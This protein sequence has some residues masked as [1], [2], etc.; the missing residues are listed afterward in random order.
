L[1]SR[2]ADVNA[3]DLGGNTP[4]HYAIAQA[5]IEMVIL[6]LDF[7]AD[8]VLGDNDNV[9]AMEMVAL[10]KNT[11]AIQAIAVV[12][13]RHC[14]KY[15]IHVAPNIV[16]ALKSKNINPHILD[17]ETA[18]KEL[19]M[20]QEQQH[21][22]LTALLQDAL[23]RA[24]QVSQPEPVSGKALDHESTPMEELP[25][26]E[27]HPEASDDNHSSYSEVDHVDDEPQSQP[28]SLQQQPQQQQPPSSPTAE[29][30]FTRD[31]DNILDKG[32]ESPTSPPVRPATKHLS[33]AT[34]LS[35]M[36]LLTPTML[37]PFLPSS[38]DPGDHSPLLTSPHDPKT[39]QPQPVPPF[40]GA[41][42]HGRRAADDGH[43]ASPSPSPSRSRSSTT[44]T[45]KPPMTI[46]DAM[47]TGQLLQGPASQSPSSAAAATS[48]HAVSTKMRSQPPHP[49]HSTKTLAGIPELH[50]ASSAT[51]SPTHRRP[52]SASNSN[53]VGVVVQ[54]HPFVVSMRNG[55]TGRVLPPRHKSAS[56]LHPTTSMTGDKDGDH[57]DRASPSSASS[58]SSSLQAIHPHS[59]HPH[60]QRQQQQ[61]QS[62]VYGD[63]TPSGGGGHV[64]IRRATTMG[65]GAGG[66]GGLRAI[67]I[68]NQAASSTS[69]PD[70]A[71]AFSTPQQQQQFMMAM[72]APPALARDDGTISEADDT[73]ASGSPAVVSSARGSHRK[74]HHHHHHHHIAPTNSVS[75][76]VMNAPSNNHNNHNHHH[77]HTNNNHHHLRDFNNSVLAHS[78]PAGQK[79]LIQQLLA[80]LPHIEPLDALTTTTT[81]MTQQP[82]PQ[83]QQQRD[84]H[85]ANDRDNDDDDDDRLPFFAAGIVQQHRLLATQVQTLHQHLQSQLQLLQQYQQQQTVA[86]AQQAQ[87]AQAQAPQTSSSGGSVTN[88][89]TTV[90]TSTANGILPP[91]TIHIPT[92]PPTLKAQHWQ[93]QLSRKRQHESTSKPSHP[94]SSSSSSSRMTTATTSSTTMMFPPAPVVPFLPDFA[95]TYAADELGDFAPEHCDV[96]VAVEHCFDCDRHSNQ[97]LRHDTRT[98]VRHA[99]AVLAALVRAIADARLAVRLFAMRSPPLTTRRLGAFEVTVAVRVDLPAAASPLPPPSSSSTSAFHLRNTHT[100]NGTGNN[101]NGNGSKGTGTGGATTTTPT[102]SKNSPGHFFGN[103]HT[104]N[105]STTN[106]NGHYHTNAS[107]GGGGGDRPSFVGGGNGQT[108]RSTTIGGTNGDDEDDEEQ[109]FLRRWVST[110]LHSKLQTKSWPNVAQLE[111]QVVSFLDETLKEVTAARNAYNV[112]HHNGA[113]T[114]TNHPH[115]PPHHHHSPAHTHDKTMPK[116][117]TT[118]PALEYKHAHSSAPLQRRL[119]DGY[120]RWLKRMKVPPIVERH[121]LDMDWPALRL[122]TTT[123][124]TTEHGHDDDA[125]AHH[126]HHQKL[127]GV[128]MLENYLTI[129]TNTGEYHHRDDHDDDGDYNDGGPL[130]HPPGPMLDFSL[131]RTSRR[132]DFERAVCA[133]FLVFDAR[134]TTT[135]GN[136]HHHYHHHH[137]Q[138][139]HTNTNNN[140]NMINN[141]NDNIM[142]MRA[143]GAS[144]GSAAPEW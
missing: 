26:D 33:A 101:G 70:V 17:A 32:A 68:H 119:S 60:Q 133:H 12:C 65:A 79:M 128:R 74:Q 54:E 10:A 41:A 97:S 11:Q 62:V 72:M 137:H 122:T 140:N 109:L 44:W 45:G 19:Q 48:T 35:D 75:S 6:L 138:D 144:T 25:A 117:M 112:V 20:V 50:A 36:S 27:P 23:S 5:N 134:L 87:Q 4:L 9:N 110:C 3:Q 52:S 118:H 81:T 121:P 63:S 18:L 16:R 82:Q 142:D 129:S 15:N 61:A 39:A 57:H 91:P 53:S 56:A 8:C 111:K 42:P 38:L 78:G 105:T 106:T 99:N 143:R 24:P 14:R 96:F 103:N 43:G 135:G 123:M 130:R 93:Y 13:L 94:S 85:D 51:T 89:T 136:H 107:G 95:G 141:N 102:G 131:A 132:C 90:Q 37:S 69:I 88:N 108:H 125:A 120:N 115:P 114:T 127:S 80:A 84:V 31:D 7:G 139:H 2:K 124:T 98:Y 46:Y 92:I 64:G 104:P 34:F 1:L 21:L 126:R 30:A 59:H 76:I 116:T 83:Q 67:A 71:V 22:S 86:Q 47:R 58:S 100:T 28:P 55:N 66:V 73:A 113:N 40:H 77:N 29:A 49:Q